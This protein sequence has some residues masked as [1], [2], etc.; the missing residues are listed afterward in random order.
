[1]IKFLQSQYDFPCSVALGKYAPT[2]EINRWGINGLRFVPFDDERFSIRGDRRRLLYKGRRRS[3][4]FTI[5]SD[6]SFE[7]DCILNREPESNVISLLMEG[8]ENF[9]FFRQP[10]FVSDPFLKGSYA[11]YK[12][13]TLLGQGT[14]KLCHIHKPLVIDARGRKCWGDLSIAGNE[15]RIT[16]DENWLSEAKYPVTV[17]PTVGTTTVGTQNKWVAEEDEYPTE[18]WFELSVP[19]NRFLIHDSI[20]GL[21]TAYYYSDFKDNE[22]G[23]RPIFYSDNSNK[24]HTRRSSGE[25]LIDLNFSGGWRSGNFYGSSIN[26]GSY[27]WFWLFCEYFWWPRFDY[28]AVCYSSWWADDYD[29]IP[30]IYPYYQYAENLN[31]KLSMY[32]S[33]SSAQIHVCT[34]T[35]GISFTDT[36]KITADFKRLSAQT[37]EITDYSFLKADFKRKAVQSVNS[38]TKPNVLFTYIRKCLISAGN[39]SGLF[40]FQLF[41]RFFSED[42]KADTAL[43]NKREINRKCEETSINYD[44]ASRIRGFIRNVFDNLNVID[45]ISNPVFFIRYVQEIKGIAETFRQYRD[46]IRFLYTEAGSVSETI[47][48]GD[49]YR[50]ETDTIHAEGSVLRHLMIFIK[51]LT[52]SFVRDFFLRRF[53]VA[54]EHLI[55]KSCIT[56]EINLES[57]I[58]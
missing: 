48:Q 24:P 31:F 35:Q 3:H 9:D 32:F 10:D 54:K 53:L 21:C 1:M 55:L 19:V 14:G 57:K 40:R 4:R 23:G 7:Y 41:N 13:E 25:N 52:S 2:W 17:D 36:K 12:K 18:L 6:T 30:N 51:L 34:L 42:I 5:H 44:M 37:T 58:N 33:Y 22:G 49:F 43:N 28:G 46:Y 27:I 16:I 15:L 20:N 26:A 45:N 50:K 8:A 47:R 38:V 11:V 29:K 39:I 56:R